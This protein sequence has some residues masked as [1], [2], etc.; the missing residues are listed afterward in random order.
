[1]SI[2]N[3]SVRNPVLVNMMMMVILI[4][5][6]L[7][8]AI[9]SLPKVGPYVFPSTDDPNKPRNNVK[10]A[11]AS[12]VIRAGL[13][14]RDGRPMKVTP[15]VLRKAYAT[16]QAMNGTPQRVLQA[17]LG[18]AA[19]TRVTDCH[20]VQVTEDAK[21]QAANVVRLMVNRG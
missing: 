16:W 1:M 4:G 12:A 2:P 5:G 14:L 15:Q 18:H 11:L 6:G 8:E 10:K 3:F 7:L 13:T 19:G 17:L 21:R 9:R 20:Y